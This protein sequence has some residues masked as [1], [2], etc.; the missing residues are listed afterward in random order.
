MGVGQNL[1]A[2]PAALDHAEGAEQTE[3]PVGHRIADT[4]QLDQVG[5]HAVNGQSS[6]G[7]LL[8]DDAE[9]PQRQV[10]PDA[11]EPAPGQWNQGPAGPTPQVDDQSRPAQMPGQDLLIEV[12]QRV[13]REEVVVFVGDVVGL[14]VVPHAAGDP[15]R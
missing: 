2:V 4:P 12:E 15:P 3:A 1:P 14:D 5:L 7:R 6:L 11:L 13:H 9:H 8:A 10:N